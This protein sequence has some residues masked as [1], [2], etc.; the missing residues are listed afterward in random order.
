MIELKNNEAAVESPVITEPVQ[1][2]KKLPAAVRVILCGLICIALFIICVLS[3]V[4]AVIRTSVSKEKIDLLVKNIDYEAICIS[5]DDNIKVSLRELFGTKTSVNSPNKSDL[6]GLIKDTEIES[7]ISE[8]LY[9]YAEFILYDKEP[10]EVD[11]RTVKKFYDNNI[12]KIEKSMGVDL[13]DTDKQNFYD[14]LDSND[15]IFDY[16]SK[17]YIEDTCGAALSA[18]RFLVSPAGIAVTAVTGIAL[19]VLFMLVTK[20]I[21]SAFTA[22]GS[23]IAFTGLLGIAASVLAL[24]GKIGISVEGAGLESVIYQT[25]LSVFASDIVN[26][27]TYTVAIGLSLTVIGIFINVIIKKIHSKTNNVM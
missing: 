7:E 10:D 9:S 23:V 8:R 18:V 24:N 4:H 14:A 12:K 3:A 13:S 16:L 25:V 27:L 15:K 5:D 20:K 1:K 19:I 22:A 2:K 17:D 6:S 26:I 21:G 11:K